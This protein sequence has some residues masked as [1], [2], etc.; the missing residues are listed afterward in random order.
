[1]IRRPP[2]STLSSSSAASDVYKRQADSIAHPGSFFGMTEFG[3]DTYLRDQALN[4]F[5]YSLTVDTWY[6]AFM[7]LTDAG[8]GKLARNRLAEVVTSLYWGRLPSDEELG[9]FVLA[10]DA[11]SPSQIEWPEF[12]RGLNT[13]RDSVVPEQ[14]ERSHAEFKS[15]QNYDDDLK[16]TSEIGSWTK[17]NLRTPSS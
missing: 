10:F 16:K 15:L 1:M 14:A 9:A 6:D 11:E 4:I 8:C 5:N 2:R 17:A 7:K 13:F 12:L 3:S